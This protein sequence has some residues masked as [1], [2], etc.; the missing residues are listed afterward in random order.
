[1]LTSETSGNALP[2]VF[3]L[4]TLFWRRARREA[5]AWCQ[6]ILLCSRID[7]RLDGM[8]RAGLADMNGGDIVGIDFLPA[9]EV[10]EQLGRRTLGAD[11]EQIKAD[12]R[13]TLKRL[14]TFRRFLG[15]T[16][17][18]TGCPRTARARGG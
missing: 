5:A 1:L 3:R 2:E 18:V 4:M 9:V 14:E 17:S 6:P 8:H 11:A 12:K 15:H 7:H 16:R 10:I 13:Y